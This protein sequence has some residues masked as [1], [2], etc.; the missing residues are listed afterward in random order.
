MN[1]K[2]GLLSFMVLNITCL[3]ANKEVELAKQQQVVQDSAAK[4]QV[5]SNNL[6]R[7]IAGAL[8][9]GGLLGSTAVIKSDLLAQT[10]LNV[11]L[12]LAAVP[13]SFSFLLNDEERKIAT[14]MAIKV[15]LLGMLGAAVTSN[16]IMKNTLGNIKQFNISKIADTL[17]G[18]TASQGAGLFIACAFAYNLFNPACDKVAKLIQKH[19]GETYDKAEIYWASIQ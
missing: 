2:L 6:Q 14:K 10:G 5:I 9:T 8:I 3:F 17:T 13:A 12:S 18:L 15:P 16:F 1:Y 19:A 4:E 11:G 7:R